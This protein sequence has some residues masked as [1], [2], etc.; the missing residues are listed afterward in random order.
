MTKPPPHAAID[1]GSNSFRLLIATLRPNG[2]MQPLV[3]K[4][5]TVRLGQ[6]LHTTGRLD[7]EA[8][9]RGLEAL[10]RFAA[11]LDA[12]H[13]QRL[14]ACATH[15]LRTAAN[16]DEFLA[17]AARLLGQPIE[18][19]DGHTEAALAL[20]GVRQAV[21]GDAHLLVADVGGGSS[22][23]IGEGGVTSLAIGTVSLTE[24]FLTP[25]PPPTPESL[26]AVRT[27][28]AAA[29]SESIL[30]FL[31]PG[32]LLVG[33]GGTA[34]AL[35]ALDLG[36]ITYDESKV[37]GHRL[38]LARLRELTGQLARLDAQGRNQLPGLDQGRGEILLAG[39]LIYEHL[40]TKLSAATLTVSDAGLLEGILWSTLAENPH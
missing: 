13:P 17:P 10:A 24:R 31:P 4:L 14:R 39:A 32:T 26:A 22:E 1:L 2:A 38:P 15:A 8:M 28:I 5:I 35:A 36:L 34:T 6:G 33:S 19:I 40:L 9:A 12:H 27:A 25:T 21:G 37:Q 30:P 7:Q 23:L 29:V 20:A 18:V 16:R 11:L 3:K